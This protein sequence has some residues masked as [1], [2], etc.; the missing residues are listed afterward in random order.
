[1]AAENNASLPML[2][3]SG[4]QR[5]EA[6]HEDSQARACW[7]YVNI[8]ASP[9]IGHENLP[10]G[11]LFCMLSEREDL[12]RVRRWTTPFVIYQSML[13]AFEASSTLKD[14]FAN[15]RQALIEMFP[16]RRRPGRTYQGFAKALRSLPASASAAL[17]AHLR[18]CHRRVAGEFWQR[19]GWTVLACDGTRVEAPRTRA[20]EAAFGCAGRNK[21]GPQLALTTLYHMNTGLPWTWRIGAGTEAERVQLWDMLDEVPAGALLVA[22]AG[23]T[24]FDLMRRLTE[25]GLFFL[26]RVGANVTLLEQLGLEMETDGRTVWL[27]PT[28][29][30]DRPPLKLRL[31]HVRTASDD[32]Y[33]VTNVFDHE[34]LSDEQAAVL[35]RMRWGVELFYRDFKQT[36]GRR[37][38][39]SASPALARLEL[40]M[41]MCGMLLLGLMSVQAMIAA[42]RDPL[43]LSVGMALRIVRQAMRTPRAWRHRG[44]LR[45]SLSAAVKDG[46]RRHA[47]K[48][49]RDWP[50]KKTESPPGAPKIRIAAEHERITAQRIYM[51]A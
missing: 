9:A 41:A 47:A 27:W 39:R 3:L 33:L 26:I 29:Q 38:L 12:P 35:Y 42:G 5:K 25:Q 48:K 43:S 8:S 44:D 16:G 22:D 34:R 45:M 20:N 4:Q 31:I 49:A 50:H 1:M 7:K 32:V 23:F 14:R 46:Y 15:A 6:F 24:G 36:L 2:F 18:D 11:P 28:K 30:R 40:H 10:H 17:G 37:K 21:T 19:F 13:M 51:A